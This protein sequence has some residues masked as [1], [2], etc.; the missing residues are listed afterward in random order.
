MK[1]IHVSDLHLGSK[2][3]TFPKEIANQR[4]VKDLDM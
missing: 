2:I 4:I 3:G 1:I